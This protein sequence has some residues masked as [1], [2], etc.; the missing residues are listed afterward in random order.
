MKLEIIIYPLL[1]ILIGLVLVSFFLIWQWFDARDRV[2]IVRENT[3]EETIRAIHR[4][5]DKCKLLLRISLGIAIF[6]LPFPFIYAYLYGSTLYGSLAYPGVV[7]IA[8]TLMLVGLKKRVEHYIGNIDEYINANEEH[9]KE[10]MMAQERERE[11]WRREAPTLNLAAR[12][13]IRETLGE[14]YDTWFEHDILLNRCVL[15]NIEE[16]LLYAQGIVLHFSEIM[17]VRQGRKDL[18]LVTSNSMYPFVTIDFGVLPI[19][20]ETGNMYKDEI[21]DLIAQQMP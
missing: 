7:I 6:Y 4:G 8:D 3:R 5:H 16:G 12:A 19:D 18:K 15:A 20:P 13:T 17:E 2:A 9:V 1:F 10:A 21:A 11:Q 14:K